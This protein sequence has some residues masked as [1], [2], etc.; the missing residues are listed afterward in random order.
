MQLMRDFYIE[1]KRT[2]SQI[3]T[4][5]D[6]FARFDMIIIDQFSI[7]KKN[8]LREA[9]IK[10][11]EEFVQAFDGS[12]ILLSSEDQAPAGMTKIKINH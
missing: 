6:K 12:M 5:K 7:G 9:M 2:Y 1:E 10:Q 11:L 4:I 3:S 8:R